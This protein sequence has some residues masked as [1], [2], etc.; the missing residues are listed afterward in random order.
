MRYVLLILLLACSSANAA[1][2][3]FELSGVITN[4]RVPVAIPESNWP[5][6]PIENPFAIGQSI[7]GWYEID[8]AN[9]DGPYGPPEHPDI[10]LN[11]VSYWINLGP[12]QFGNL[13]G[14]GGVVDTQL[15]DG[16]S[17]SAD[18]MVT[19]DIVPIAQNHS[20]GFSL[21]DDLYLSLY[22]PSGA[23]FGLSEDT[24]DPSKFIVGTIS[25]AGGVHGFSGIDVAGI[26]MARQV[27]EP[28]TRLLMVSC[29]LWIAGSSLVRKGNGQKKIRP[30]DQCNSASMR[31]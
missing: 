11:L 17:G 21:F 22:A 5:T 24:F 6:Y 20:A 30:E 27:P 18:S 13:Y 1:P 23:G 15:R 14:G 29:L 7:Y 4:V 25:G 10:F 26:V 2:V 9:A 16:A 19:R 3:R 31:G 8:W 12:V 28:D